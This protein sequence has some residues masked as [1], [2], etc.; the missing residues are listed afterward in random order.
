MPSTRKQK[1]KEK[2]SRQSDVISDIENLD[3]MLGS[4]QRDNCDVQ[5][6]TSENEMDLES[7]RREESSNHNENDYRSY[8]KTNISEKSGLTVGTRR[9]I[10]SKISSQISRKLEEMQT[11]LITHILEAINTVIERKVLPSIKN[12][13]KTQNSAE[14]TILDLWSDGLYPISFSQVRPQK[15]LQ[16]ERLHPEN[17]THVALDAQNDF[18][19]L[20]TMRCDRK[21][22][23]RENSV[24]FNHSDDEN[25]YDMVTGANLTT[26]MVPAFLTG[27]PMQSRIITPHQQGIADDT[28]DPSQSI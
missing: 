28:L 25:G 27:R 2:R 7:N 6:R 19:R 23:C 13:I 8:L 21:N 20:I 10:R 9:A 17:D 14:N 16:S 4:Y 24:E 26:Q 1:A 18:P 11:N 15:D 22:H 5:D 12:A 3:V